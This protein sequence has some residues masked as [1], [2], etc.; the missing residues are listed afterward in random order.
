MLKMFLPT[1]AMHIEIINKYLQEFATLKTSDI[2]LIKVLVVFLRPNGMTVQ[3]YNPVLVI[4][5][6]FF[7]SSGAIRICQ[8]PDYKSK[9]VNHDEFPNWLITSSTNGIENES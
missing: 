5:V 8:K 7:M 2:V 9:V 3:S 6:V 4:K 1:F